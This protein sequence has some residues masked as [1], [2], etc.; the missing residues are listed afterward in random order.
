LISFTCR[1]WRIV[2][3]R[4]PKTRTYAKPTRVDARAEQNKRAF[5][6]PLP[7]AATVYHARMRL[8]VALVG[9][10]FVVLSA[11]AVVLAAPKK[12]PASESE[13][14]DKTDKKDDKKASKGV[15]PYDQAVLNANKALAA[16][17]AGGALDEAVGLYRKAIEVDAARPEAHLYLGGVLYLKGDYPGAI[18]AASTA[19]TRAKAD[20][21]FT[22]FEGKAL[23]LEATAKEASGRLEDAKAAWLQ[24]ETFAK[25]HPDQEY[26][27]GSGDAPPM[28]VKVFPGSAVDRVAKIENAARLKTDYAHV[29]ELVLKRMKELGIEAKDPKK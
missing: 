2:A 12:K 26:P 23:F 1:T 11:S 18:E 24:Y 14:T 3:E 21:S 22:N 27:K 6:L 15:T 19:N 29:K 20:K 25:E 16:G 13:K 10:G 28:L 5:A 9:V 4:L 8:R 7:D 17:A